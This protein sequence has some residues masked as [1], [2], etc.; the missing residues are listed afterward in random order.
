[1]SAS[2]KAIVFDIETGPLPAPK[3]EALYTPIAD[4]EVKIGNIKD[5]LKIAAKIEEAKADHRA[6]FFDRAALSAVTGRVLAIGYADAETDEAPKADAAESED[7][8][9]RTFW[10]AYKANRG[11]QWV[12]FNV[13]RFDLPFIIRRSWALGIPV[14]TEIRAGRYWHAGIIDLRDIWQLGDRE[15]HGNLD[16]IAKLFG[17]GAKTGDG[18]HF[19]ELLKK[20]REA[21]LAYLR[22]DVAMT[23][24]VYRRMNIGWSY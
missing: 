15:A 8:I 20:D 21:A 3:I 18:A 19:A 17:V 5:P 1:M 23:R 11:A 4:E 7:L 2:I 16:T 12:G 13:C 22:N 14:P 24:A 9:L 6:A 10:A